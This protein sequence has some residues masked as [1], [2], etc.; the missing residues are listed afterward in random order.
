MKKIKCVAA[1]TPAHLAF[2]DGDKFFVRTPDYP[3]KPIPQNSAPDMM[4]AALI[5]KWGF[6]PVVGQK[7]EP[8]PEIDSDKV[9]LVQETKAKDGSKCFRVVEILP[10][11]GAGKGS[12]DV[13]KQEDSVH[14]HYARQFSERM[15]KYGEENF[16]QFEAYLAAA[17]DEGL[18]FDKALQ[19]ADMAME[20]HDGT[21]D[22]NNQ[23]EQDRN[24]VPVGDAGGRKKADSG[25]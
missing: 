6:Y 22:G 1:Q 3:D 10:Y 8:S 24:D 4:I 2:Q 13:P 14:D 23:S 5:A 21:A 17:I 25:T 16:E 20:D 18:E 12:D 15:K 19:V 9:P 7:G 11:E